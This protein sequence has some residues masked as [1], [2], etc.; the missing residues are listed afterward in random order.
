M[1]TFQNTVGFVEESPCV[2]DL[3]IKEN[4]VYGKGSEKFTIEEIL[5]TAMDANI[6]DLIIRLPEVTPKLYSYGTE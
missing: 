3:T 1:N 5:K 4:I 2:Y 6:H